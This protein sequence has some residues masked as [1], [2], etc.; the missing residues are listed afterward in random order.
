MARQLRHVDENHVAHREQRRRQLACRLIRRRHPARQRQVHCRLHAAVHEHG[1]VP[2]SDCVPPQRRWHQLPVCVG[3]PPQHL[4]AGLRH[5]RRLLPR[6]RRLNRNPVCRS[7]DGGRRHR[8][9]HHELP[10]GLPSGP[11]AQ[12]RRR[13]DSRRQRRHRLSDQRPGVRHHL[14]HHPAELHCPF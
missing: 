2:L 12:R 5:S 6:D 14:V 13:V 8:Q 10:A 3:L 9:R 4:C 11:A 1:H 7:H